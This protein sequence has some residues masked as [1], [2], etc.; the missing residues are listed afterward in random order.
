MCS[1][2]GN[3]SI[4]RSSRALALALAFFL[5]QSR[6]SGLAE[7]GSAT[8]KVPPLAEQD[9]AFLSITFH[10]GGCCSP[11]VLLPLV[12]LQVLSLA[13]A[14]FKSGDNCIDKVI[15]RVQDHCKDKDIKTKWGKCEMF[16]PGCSAS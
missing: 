16:S 3:G 14:T 11:P 7:I 1:L 2:P 15:L 12:S 13:L 9:L 10:G 8:V 4:A 6:D 5:L